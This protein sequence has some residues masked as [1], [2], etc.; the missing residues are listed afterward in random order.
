MKSKIMNENQIT[1]LLAS[2]NFIKLKK[3]I[4]QLEQEEKNFKYQLKAN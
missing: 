3:L 2:N 4:N 1:Y